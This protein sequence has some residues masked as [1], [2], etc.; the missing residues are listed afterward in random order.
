VTQRGRGR[1]GLAGGLL[2]QNDYG[3]VHGSDARTAQC[4]LGATYLADN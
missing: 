2:D 1:V 3:C 4:R